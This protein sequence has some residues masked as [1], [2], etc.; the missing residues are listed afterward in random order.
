VTEGQVA[1]DAGQL[2]LLSTGFRTFLG[3]SNT[4]PLSDDFSGDTDEISK[5]NDELIAKWR[6]RLS[7]DKA[8]RASLES[9]MGANYT[10]RNRKK[11]LSFMQLESEEPH[12]KF[13][14]QS[15]DDGAVSFMGAGPPGNVNKGGAGFIAGRNTL[16][17][18]KDA[19]Y[20]C[21]PPSVRFADQWENLD[22]NG[23][24]VWSLDEAEEDANGFEKKFRA[25]P[26]LVFRAIT[27]GLTDRV[28]VDPNLWVPPEVQE[29]REIPKAYFDYW[30]GDAAICSYADPKVCGTLWIAASLVRLS[31]QTTRAKI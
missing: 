17:T 12:W 27:V 8:E 24:G 30:M 9:V 22:A 14:W 26:F 5:R 18:M 20:N 21:L 10:A 1:K 2:T 25:K 31:A 7:H 11:A 29:M 23:D 3:Q 16:C 19:T 6:K 4:M 15:P 13:G 28:A